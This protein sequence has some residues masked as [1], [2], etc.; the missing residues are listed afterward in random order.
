MVCGEKTKCNTTEE[1]SQWQELRYDIDPKVDPDILGSMTDMS[2][3]GD[4]YTDGIFSLHNIEH[5]YAHEV[6][7][8]LREFY[9]VLKKDGYVV[10]TCPD[11]QAVC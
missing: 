3:I 11:L 1:F 7:V 2:I 9:R 6:P 4:E 5:L 10:L 8:A